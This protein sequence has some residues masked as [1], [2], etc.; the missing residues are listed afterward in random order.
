MI[1]V[2]AMQPSLLWLRFC[3]EALPVDG[4]GRLL[5]LLRGVLFASPTVLGAVRGLSLSTRQSSNELQRGA[6][7]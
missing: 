3:Y 6:G 4:G 5:L 7:V 2:A 1:P